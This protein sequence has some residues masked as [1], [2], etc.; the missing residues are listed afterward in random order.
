MDETYERILFEIDEEKQEY[1]IRLL[2]CLAFSRRPLRVK[3]L[4]EVLAIQFDTAIPRLDTS[5]RPGDAQE[6]VLSACSTLVAI[7]HPDPFLHDD[8]FRFVQF[9]HY[10]VKEFLTSERLANSDKGN[11]SQYYISPERAHTILAQSCI[12]TLLQ[13]DICIGRITDRFPLAK[14]AAQNWFRHAQC[15]DVASQMLDG[16]ECLFDPDKK[17][18]AAW[19]SIH[20]IDCR[21]SSEKTEAS[22]LYYAAL[23]GIGSLVEHFLIRRQQDPNES[24]GR[25]GTPLHVAALSGH[26][27]IARHLL[28]HSADAN[29]R[30]MNKMTPLHSAIENGNT[31]IAQLL[32][33]HGADA[34]IY[35]HG[36][37]ETV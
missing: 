16:M 28:E 18:F 9:S 12:S 32:L 37:N 19:I 17:H 30:D 33:N 1:A 23:C 29:A 22:P 26:T 7:I 20:D 6:A 21:W 10:S 14:Y 36:R 34:N 13:T 4:A 15:D 11:L 24:Y 27:T 3:E 35:D 2:R 31:D 5:L 25:Q 8:Y